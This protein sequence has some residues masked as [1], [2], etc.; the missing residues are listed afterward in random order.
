MSGLEPLKNLNLLYAEDDNKIQEQ[1]LEI[2][3]NFF[4]N[5][6][7][8]SNGVDALKLYKDKTIHIIVT[9]I[10]MPLMDGLELIEEIRREDDTTPIFITSSYSDKEFLLQAVKLKLVDYI[11]QP[12][13]YRDIKQTLTKTVKELEKNSVLEVNVNETCKYSPLNKTLTNDNNEFILQNKEA[14]LL[15]LL[16]KNRQRL[17]T[18]EMI[19][20]TLYYDDVLSEGGLKNLLLKLRKK[21]GKD[22]IL[23]LKNIGYMLK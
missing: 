1:Y 20:N 16:L 5:V 19:E 14:L 6:Y 8:A 17:V 2:F 21:I 15:E 4:A 3:N 10:K 23:T 13:T 12:A 7:T 22:S 18:K 9:D 11:I